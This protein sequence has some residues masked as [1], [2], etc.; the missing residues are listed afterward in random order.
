MTDFEFA[1]LFTERYNKMLTELDDAD[2]ELNLEQFEKLDRII[3]LFSNLVSDSSGKIDSIDM[4]PRMEHGGVTATITL[5][6]VKGEEVKEFCSALSEASAIT[7]DAT[8]DGVCISVTVPH[9]FR[10]KSE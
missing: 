6:Y 2:Y 7:M 3:K 9:V 10:R 5:V 8:D 1:R 4:I